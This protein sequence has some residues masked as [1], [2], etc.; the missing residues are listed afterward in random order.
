MRTGRK[1]FI[2]SVNTL[3]CLLHPSSTS[4]GGGRVS[5]AQSESV[6]KSEF[7]VSMVERVVRATV[8][9]NNEERVRKR[10]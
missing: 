5:C 8:N 7:C 1:L 2:Q 10:G 9:G 6:G 3:L 4:P